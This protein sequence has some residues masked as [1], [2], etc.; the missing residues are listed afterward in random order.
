MVRDNQGLSHEFST[1]VRTGMVSY[2]DKRI[3]DI[4]TIRTLIIH[5]I[6]DVFSINNELV[7]IQS[8]LKINLSAPNTILFRHRNWI[9]PV[10]LTNNGYLG[11]KALERERRHWRGCMR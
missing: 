6:E 5:W 1:E 2:T 4:A 3:L 10:P 8:F 7:T 9:A 11:C